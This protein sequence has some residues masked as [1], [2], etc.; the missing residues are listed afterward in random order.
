M[1][2][3]GSSLN[4]DVFYVYPC[5]MDVKRGFFTCQVVVEFGGF[6]S[7]CGSFG[8]G[9]AGTLV[10]CLNTMNT[11]KNYLLLLVSFYVLIQLYFIVQAVF[12]GS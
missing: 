2:T 10:L 4:K 3:N 7:D 6:V 9:N 1:L 12:L 11:V 5:F 8:Y